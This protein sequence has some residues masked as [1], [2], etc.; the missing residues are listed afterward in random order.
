M[1][2]QQEVKSIMIIISIFVYEMKLWWMA[3]ELE[4]Q[5]C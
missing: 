1:Y 4:E 2:W 5:F 3:K